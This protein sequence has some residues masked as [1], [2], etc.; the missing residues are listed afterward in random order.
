MTLGILLA[1]T[2]VVFILAGK[3]SGVGRLPGDLILQRGRWTVFLPVGT[4]IVLSI[5]L[6][7]LLNLFFRR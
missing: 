2:G 1:A 4:M 6:T 7:I 5:L 3:F